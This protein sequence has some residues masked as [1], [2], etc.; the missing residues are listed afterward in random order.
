[1]ELIKIPFI[2]TQEAKSNTLQKTSFT[3]TDKQTIHTWQNVLL[4]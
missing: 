2:K 1:L 4:A 3:K